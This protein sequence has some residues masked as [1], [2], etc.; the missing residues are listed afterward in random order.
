M[1][2]DRVTVFLAN[3]TMVQSQMTMVLDHVTMALAHVTM[4]SVCR[5]NCCGNCTPISLSCPSPH[6]PTSVSHQ[7]PH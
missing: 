2:F 5:T 6:L 3:I 4:V 7:L 1:D